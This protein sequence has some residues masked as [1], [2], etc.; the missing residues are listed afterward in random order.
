M[1]M[2]NHVQ[3]HAC[4]L[5]RRRRVKQARIS[6]DK[7]QIGAE[8]FYVGCR[9]NSLLGECSHIECDVMRLFPHGSYNESVIDV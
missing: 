9:M 8:L 3:F 4:P 2:A 7:S 5:E 6:A 1:R